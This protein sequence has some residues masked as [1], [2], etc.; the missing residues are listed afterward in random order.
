MA[1]KSKRADFIR[2]PVV[3]GHAQTEPV[4]P[5]NRIS[6]TEIRIERCTVDDAEKAVSPPLPPPSVPPLD[7]TA[8]LSSQAEGLYA[9]FGE[10]FWEMR[11]PLA[12]R[13]ELSTRIRRMAAL[14]RPSFTMPSMNWI[15]AVITSTGEIAGMA[16]WVNP[17]NPI[18]NFWRRSAVEFYGW[19]K[20]FNWSA[21]DLE[22]MWAGVDIKFWDEKFAAD[23]ATRAKVMNGEEHW[24]LAPLFTFPEYQGRGVGKL[25]LDWGTQ[26]A[27][28]T[29]P[30]TPMYLESAPY[31]RAVYMHVGF[32][33]VGDY[34]FL[35]RGPKVVRGLEAEDGYEKGTSEVG[36]VEKADADEVE[37]DIKA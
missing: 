17:G 12:L 26:R 18:H 27:D 24:F 9:C 31:A 22:E 3:P 1:D 10:D 33:P 34:N 7:V 2:I 25:L 20:Q 32:E 21:A 19:D 4:E 14:T 36:V 5:E 23:D 15:K 35:R 8:N 6:E 30:A 28:A 13:P 11:E 16:G 29:N 37:G